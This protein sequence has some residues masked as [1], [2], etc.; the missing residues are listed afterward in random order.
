MLT[1]RGST[2]CTARSSPGPPLELLKGCPRIVAAMPDTVRFSL[3]EHRRDEPKTC[4]D[5]S[6]S[7]E[8]Y[9]L[10]SLAAASKASRIS[11]GTLCPRTRQRMI[12]PLSSTS[13][14]LCPTP[15]VPRRLPRRGCPHGECPNGSLSRRP[16]ENQRRLMRV[17]WGMLT[18]LVEAGSQRRFGRS[19]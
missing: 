14:P 16:G 18:C 7:G 3:H 8:R 10:A 19:L 1:G 11:W 15:S 13:A 4:H 9:T 12:G 6:Y 2:P 17:N 5:T